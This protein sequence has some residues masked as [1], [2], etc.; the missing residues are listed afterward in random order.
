MQA[1]SPIVTDGQPVEAFHRAMQLRLTAT[2]SKRM[3]I[4]SAAHTRQLKDNLTRAS[5]PYID[6]D[7]LIRSLPASDV[8]WRLHALTFASSV[9]GVI[10]TQPVRQ[11]S[12][13]LAVAS[14][15]GFAVIIDGDVADTT[16]KWSQHIAGWGLVTPPSE[17]EPAVSVRPD[18]EFGNVMRSAISRW[19]QNRGFR[20]AELGGTVESID[21][22]R[23]QNAIYLNLAIPPLT[24]LKLFDG[25]VDVATD[26][27]YFIFAMSGTG[28]TFLANQA[29]VLDGDT[30]IEWPT[31]PRFWEVWPRHKQTSFG[32][33]NLQKLD[34]LR[35]RVVLFNPDS[36]ALR[37]AAPTLKRQLLY[38]MA[39]ANMHRA[40]LIARTKKQG[41]K[42]PGVEELAKRGAFK[43]LMTDVGAYEISRRMWELNL[44]PDLIAAYTAIATYLSAR[45]GFKVIT[46]IPKALYDDGR[47]YRYGETALHILPSKHSVFA[48]GDHSIQNLAYI[49]V[50]NED[51][52]MP[53]PGTGLLGVNYV[54]VEHVV[55]ERFELRDLAQQAYQRWLINW[56]PASDRLQSKA[57][58]SRVIRAPRDLFT[59]VYAEGDL[60]VSNFAIS[61]TINAKS[62]VISFIKSQ[63]HGVYTLPFDLGG[64]WPPGYLGI[65]IL[66]GKFTRPSHG[67]E[68]Y[69]YN[70]V[71]FVFDGDKPD[72]RCTVMTFQTFLTMVGGVDMTCDGTHAFTRA[73]FVV[74]VGDA[75]DSR[76]QTPL[77]NQTHLVK[78]VSLILRDVYGHDNS[79][80]HA[81]RR[82]AL[83]AFRHPLVISSFELDDNR[84]NGGVITT[85]GRV[86]VAVAG[87][88]INMLL[89]SHFHVIDFVRYVDTIIWNITDHYEKRKK[90]K[91][92][93]T[94]EDADELWHGYFDWRIALDVYISMA[95]ELRIEVN[96]TYVNY[97]L[98]T[99]EGL[100]K[101]FDSFLLAEGYQAKS[102]LAAA[103]GALDLPVV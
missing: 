12:D 16:N 19:A 37:I 94:L 51:V 76:Y 60:S 6:L 72:R 92:L 39:P 26:D 32:V 42:Q 64:A 35:D 59:Y 96:M 10:I 18:A 63:G 2:A 83:S 43:Q 45:G 29:N 28:K 97:V 69:T 99:L 84:V 1:V 75:I 67:F 61:N 74:L 5:L 78:D 33:S 3:Y 80:L 49:T 65:T 27:K 17:Y 40:N 50:N 58:I 81:R 77:N 25:A 23:N 85:K 41:T 89:A 11:L 70:P 14:T 66:D 34:S 30:V 95:E 47:Q 103:E 62:R 55:G 36:E 52:V 4:G 8:F 86:L 48:L 68:D 20:I 46:T 82:A 54:I 7:D 56:T 9:P 53:A 57:I 88:M 22:Y 102:Y 98:S 90:P 93:F 91:N 71:D 31:E 87:H 24:T 100:V 21:M 101:R 44:M 15:H 73:W 79:T 38:Y 13:L